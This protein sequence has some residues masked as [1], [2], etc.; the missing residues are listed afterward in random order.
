[1][2]DLPEAGVW[3]QWHSLVFDVSAHEIWGALLHGGRLVV[4]P[5]SVASA[6]DELHALLVAERVTVLCQTPSAVGMLSPEGLESM[7][8]VVAGEA[9]PVEVVDRWAPGRVMINAYGP[10]EATVYAAMSAPLEAGSGVVPIGSPVPG[11]ALFVLDKW[12]RPVPEGVVGELYVAGR[13]VACGYARRGGLTASRFVA[14]PFGSAGAPGTRMY[15]TGDLVRWADD[16]QLQYLGRADEQVKIRGYRIELGEVQAAL[17]GLDGVEQAAVIAREDRPGDKRLVGYVTGTADPVEARAALG[18]RLP[19]Y[20][21]P[22]A[23]VVLDALPL[24][25]NGKLD[26]RALPAPEYQNASRYRAPASAVEE[27]LAG[28]Y[29]QVLGVD[30]VGVDDSFF[31][32]GGDSI[33]SMQV[34][35]RARAAGVTFRPRDIFVEQT[36]AKLAQVAGVATEDD[37]IDEGVGPVVATPIIRWLASVDG[38]VDQFNQTMVVQAPTGVAEADVLEV[39]QALL[40]RHATLRLRV[41]DDG[42]DGWSLYV[43]EAGSVEAAACLQTVDVLSDAALVE[44]RERLNPAAGTMLRAVWAAATG[45]LALIIHHLAVDGVSW[46]VLLEDLN[47]A[48]AQH[49]SGQPV[50]LPVGGT[51]FA[52]WSSLLE[53]YAHRPEVAGLAEAWRQ[54]TTLPAALPAVR[55]EVDT[56]ASAEQMT[57]SLDAETTRL[58]LGEVPAAFHAGVQDILLIAFGLAWTQFLANGGGPIGIDVEGHG[59]QEELAPHV[60]LSRSVGWFTTKYPV[61]LAVG[62]LD[63]AQVVA[64]DAALGAVLKDA[65]E[66]LR[67]LPDGLTYGLLRYLNPE[68]DLAGTD[69]VIGFNYLGRLGATA[70][71]PGELWRISQESLSFTG[72][73]SAAVPMPLMHTVELNA[74]TMDTDAGPQ[75]HANWLWAPSALDREQVSRVS[76]LWF[77]ALAGI[78]AHVRGGGGGL[79]PSDIAPARLT[80]QQIDQLCEQYQVADVLPL[81]PLQQG[82]LFHAGFGQDPGDDVYAVQLGITVTGDLDPERLRDAVQTVVNRHPNLAARFC[83]QFGEPVQV[84][85]ADPAMAWRYVQLGAE[86]LGTEAQIDQVCAEERAAVSDLADRPAFRA[87]LI[88]TGDNRYR[89]VLTNH[90]IVMDGWSLPILLREILTSYYGE[91]LPAAATYRSYLTWLAEQDRAA[92]NAAWR[93]VLDGF[94]TPTLV[95]PSARMRPGRRGV[96]SYRV[97]AETTRALGELARSCHTTV[98]TVLQAAWAQ[99]LMWLTGQHDVA[100]GTAVSGR[101]AELP[102][103]ETIIGLL[104][105]T[106]P[107][108]AHATAATTVAELLDQ[109]QH[110]YNDTIE[111]E[112]LSLSEIHRA[113]GHDLLFDTLFLYEN[114]P[115]DTGVPLGF[116]DLAIAEVTNREYNHYPLS[117]M[118]LPGRELGLRVEFDTEVFDA[119]T[120]ES[121]VERFKRLLADMTADPTQRLSSLDVVD[122]GELARLAEWGNRAVLSEPVAGVSIPELFAGQVARVPDAAALTFEGRS[123]SYREL[124]EAAN[125]LAHLLADRGAG[126][127]EC[128]ALLLPRSAEAIVAILAVLKSGAAY[129]P[130]DPALPAARIEF[131][132]GDA[133]PVA[134]VTTAAAARAAGRVRPD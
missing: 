26:K 80:Q 45:Q 47:I 28:I 101:P 133:S 52:R 132:L 96:E 131:L 99:L 85:P 15:R 5:E 11:A 7:A 2:P 94:D 53:E 97:S 9:C 27:T 54:V 128:V 18:D 37:V 33:L 31:D 79:T 20:M 107:V 61:S 130:I 30:R 121:L 117:V 73:A 100:F 42:A 70:D 89:F 6:P 123:L 46:R 81:T 22:A 86:D 43:P 59:R 75:L 110:A 65:K 93:E 114:Y 40:D 49:H 91:R 19:A 56:Y 77:E 17:A 82:L 51:S 32:L 112:H 109:L 116:H 84:I 72:A 66:Q 102:G 41:D 16:G 119:I 3:A 76:Q 34:V 50:A 58:L 134:A 60:D 113:T 35:A 71:L 88:R 129:L 92:A 68:V 120:I 23:I 118:A 38:P 39:L 4:V 87:A 103:A 1:M 63:W 105:N 57:V 48:W 125:R 55:P 10:T 106:V 67:A 108:R 111:H 95:S 29:A 126:P 13:G 122:E 90:H 98:N 74:G 14:C 24:T 127:G 36:V 21:V 25:V 124:D 104:I 62:G 69:P 64:G 44:A 83:P 12:L 115:I 8:L 78:C